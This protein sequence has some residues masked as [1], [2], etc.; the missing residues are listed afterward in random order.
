MHTVRNEQNKP[1]MSIKPPIAQQMPLPIQLRASS[2]FASYC[3][4]QNQQALN[5]LQD[6]HS[7]GPNP[8]VFLFG[9]GAVGKTHLLQATCV[10]VAQQKKQVGYFPLRELHQYG[11]ELLQGAEQMDLVCLDDVGVVLHVKDWCLALFN[12]YRQ[13]EERGAKML[14]ADEQSPAVLKIALPD[15]A[16]RILAGTVL[17]VQSL[18]EGGQ[19]EALCM[20]AKLRGLILSEEVLS[21]LL[22]RLPRDMHTLCDFIDHLDLASLASQRK[23]TIPFV[24][25]V[26]LQTG[27]A[28]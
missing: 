26:L 7:S 13:L 9:S 24:K 17:R 12:L 11:T 20:H 3:A 25:E 19:T 23:L 5:V 1:L 8:V 2:V 27:Y 16:S 21:Y 6:L 28:V 14:L 22:R 15:L 10:S 18:D 4:G